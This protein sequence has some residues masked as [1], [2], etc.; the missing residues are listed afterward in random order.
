MKGHKREREG[1]KMSQ[2]VK[3][4]GDNELE[5]GGNGTGDKFGVYFLKRSQQITYCRVKSWTQGKHK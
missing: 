2:T 5:Q 4:S 1:G 3:E